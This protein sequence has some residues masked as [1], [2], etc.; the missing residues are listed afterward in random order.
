ML[1]SQLYLFITYGYI[2]VR[3]RRFWFIVQ[4][5]NY[6]QRKVH[7]YVHSKIT[8]AEWSIAIF[9]S[10]FRTMG[11]ILTEANWWGSTST[12]VF[13]QIHPGGFKTGKVISEG[14]SGKLQTRS[15][16]QRTEFSTVV[17]SRGG[18]GKR[19]GEMKGREGE[20]RRG[21]RV[22]GRGRRVGGRRERGEK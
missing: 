4:K 21:R 16:Y 2:L 19:E 10:L 14:S 11:L 3:W 5:L 15:M 8:K 12:I 17:C 9:I 20:V 13:D 6:Q 22:G 18:Q 7:V 1:Y